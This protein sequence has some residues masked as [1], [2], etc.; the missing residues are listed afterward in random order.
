V[1]TGLKMSPDSTEDQVLAKVQ[2][3]STADVLALKQLESDH[4]LKLEEL[5][6]KRVELENEAERDR[7][8]DVQSA[9]SRDMALM[10]AGKDNLRA[11]IMLALAFL[12]VIAIAVIL[13][14]GWV[15]AGSATAGFLYSIGGMFAKN[16][17]QA[18]DFEF[19]SSRGSKNKDAIMANGKKS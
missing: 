19:G 9:R 16:I 15:D 11:H 4:K 14:V 8:K 2:S 7:L 6:I 10:A 5:A 13:G 12:A 3:L 17:G 18:F 1:K